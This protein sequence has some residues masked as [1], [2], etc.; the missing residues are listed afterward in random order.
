M[1]GVQTCALPILRAGRITSATLAAYQGIL[2]S[3][4]LL[5]AAFV[6]SGLTGLFRSATLLS[7][8]A[9]QFA[10]S[11]VRYEFFPR[12]GR[13]SNS[14]ELDAAVRKE[15]RLLITGMAIFALV[16]VAFR[17]PVLE[18]AFARQFSDASTLLVFVLAGDLLRINVTII[19]YALYA[20]H[21]PHWL[22][23]IEATNGFVLVGLFLWACLT[24]PTYWT[25]GMA[26]LGAHAVAALVAFGL[27]H[28]RI[29]ATI[30][31]REISISLVALVGIAVTSVIGSHLVLAGLSALVAILLCIERSQ[32]HRT[33]LRPT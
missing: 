26:Y 6:G 25:L 18:I 15:I 10:N 2:Y 8:G 31:K 33:V 24:N 30:P 22:L 23:A 16:V 3:L 28:K 7:G 27:A 19:G 29:F 5:L 13:L 1:T 9:L 20:S 4:P 32:L 12:I 17:A 14:N 11:I 21:G